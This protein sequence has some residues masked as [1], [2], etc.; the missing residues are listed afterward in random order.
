MATKPRQTEKELHE[1]AHD[2][3]RKAGEQAAQASRSM[4]D[5]GERFASAGVEAGRRNTQSLTS[6]WR[7]GSE[8]ASRI[9]ERSM[10][11]LSTMFGMTGD[12]ARQALTYSSGNL[13]AVMESMT[14]IADGLQ[15]AS[16]E[17]IQFV[18]GSIEQNSNHLEHYQRCRSLQEL[19]ALQTQIARDNLELLL[20]TLS[21][22]SEHSMTVAE[23]AARTVSASTLAPR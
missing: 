12:S 1:A 6:T 21:R 7:S 22:A 19:M 15:R 8:A 3:T 20:R 18:H 5:T 23:E 16:G 4:A 10:E 14:I 2:V 9:A 13:Q 17:W 11:Q